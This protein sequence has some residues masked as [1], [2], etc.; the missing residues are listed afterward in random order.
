MK[1]VYRRLEPFAESRGAVECSNLAKERPV[2]EPITLEVDAIARRQKHMVPI[3]EASVVKPE[4]DATVSPIGARNAMTDRD[5]DVGQPRSKP[6]RTCRRRNAA[7]CEWVAQRLRQKPEELGPGGK[8][9]RSRATDPDAFLRIH[10]SGKIFDFIVLVE[11]DDP[12]AT[13]EEQ[14]LDVVLG[15]KS[16]RLKRALAC[17]DD[18][19]PTSCELGQ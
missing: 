13:N 3:H 8:P 18:D 19:H 7:P 4:L 10:P 5:I 12:L 16:G 17:P 14:Y 11:P 1:P 9:G 6:T 2:E 15:K